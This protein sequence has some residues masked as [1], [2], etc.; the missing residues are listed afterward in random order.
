MDYSFIK[1]SL[2]QKR[3]ILFGAGNVGR[4]TASVFMQ[5]KPAYFVDN[6]ENKH[7]TQ[8]NGITIFP[9]QRLQE[10]SKESIF[11]IVACANPSMVIDICNQL[12][13]IG[14]EQG[15]HFHLVT[16]ILPRISAI[17]HCRIELIDKGIFIMSEI[18]N[19]SKEYDRKNTI[20]IKSASTEHHYSVVFGGANNKL[21]I[22]PHCIFDDLNIF[23]FG[24]NS[25]I[26]I[27]KNAIVNG[28]I[29]VGSDNII[30]IG[31]SL[32]ARSTEIYARE[33]GI[34]K[35]GDDCLFAKDVLIYQSDTHPIFSKS[36]G[37]R[38][39]Q[40]KNV[41]IG[42]HVW[43]G[44]HTSVLGGAE[45]G[46]GSVIGFGSIVAGKIP[47]DVVAVGNPAKVIRSD[48][49]WSKEEFVALD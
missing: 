12:S 15:I 33:G 10:E 38:T 21:I 19:E 13:S 36:S 44:R 6:D 40:E 23:F 39:N 16:D 24:N 35:I 1:H 3:I 26:E 45:I 31:H 8:I 25:S 20:E 11:I 49:C 28:I 27:H 5:Y 32:T 17:T 7:F 9:I 48:I 46:D 4:V 37:E 41:S 43:L 34:V 14:F 29:S 22:H 18:N 30:T 47:C 42:N 2:T